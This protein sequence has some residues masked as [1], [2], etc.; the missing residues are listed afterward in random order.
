ML[1]VWIIYENSRQ[2]MGSEIVIISPTPL[3]KKKYGIASPL[4]EKLCNEVFR[5]S[6]TF[7]NFD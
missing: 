4:C 6:V 1:G 7:P 5:N 2:I 3:N